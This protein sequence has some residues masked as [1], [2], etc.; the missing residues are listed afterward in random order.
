ME[1]RR[2]LRPAVIRPVNAEF[3]LLRVQR[4]LFWRSRDEN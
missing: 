4:V 2:R 1:K 3:L